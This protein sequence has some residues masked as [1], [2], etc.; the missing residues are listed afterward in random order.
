MTLQSD[1]GIPI[2]SRHMRGNGVHTFRLINSERRPFLFKWY[3]EPMVGSRSRVYDEVTE[4]AGIDNDYFQ[5]EMCAKQ[6]LQVS[7]P[8]G[9]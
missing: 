3:W 4:I 2:Y 1:L 8:S 9:D 5:V 6:L 7:S